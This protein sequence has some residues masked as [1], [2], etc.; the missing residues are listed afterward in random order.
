M[1]L[2]VGNNKLQQNEVHKCKAHSISFNIS[3]RPLITLETAKTYF[4]NNNFTKQVINQIQVSTH[5][6]TS[7]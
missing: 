2:E 6:F 5:L 3:R 7:N 4:N 1:L